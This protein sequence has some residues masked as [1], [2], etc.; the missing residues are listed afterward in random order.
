MTNFR[1]AEKRFVALLMS[2]TLCPRTKAT[3]QDP[4]KNLSHFQ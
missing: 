2:I 1:L 4:A 3:K